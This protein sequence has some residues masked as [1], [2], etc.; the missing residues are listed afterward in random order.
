MSKSWLLRPSL[1]I[2]ALLTKSNSALLNADKNPVLNR[3]LRWAIYNHFCAGTNS[4]EVSKAVEDVKRLGYHGIILGYA[5]EVVLD[6]VEALEHTS[7]GDAKYGAMHYE[8]IDEWKRGNLETLEMLGSGDFIALK[9]T[10]AGP[11]A[12]DAM[13][14]GQPMP[15]YLDSALDEICY[16]TNKKG[17][18]V[19]LDA[20]QQALQ[21]TLDEWAIG[22]MRKHNQGGRA[23][24]YNT[25]QGYLKGSKANAERHI[26]LAAQEG[27]T[28]AIKLV[29]GAYI[30]NEIRSLIH[31]TKEDTDRSYDA[32][33]DMFISRKMPEG[34]QNLRFPDAALFLATHNAKS[35]EKGLRTHKERVLAGLPTTPLE[36]GQILGMAD[37]LSCKLLQD[38]DKSAADSNMGDKSPRILKCIPWGSVGECMGYLYRRAVENRGAVERTQHMAEAMR[39]EVR[40]RVLG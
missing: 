10:G 9:L 21:P 28:V 1:A 38:H 19:W 33:A 31:D 27:W 4:R 29:R 40:R 24:L 17:C 34:V 20:E 5:K 32:I 16:E 13:Q 14:A 26:T 35:A 30:E 18:R 2:M 7:S 6:P 12:L 39:R 25:I 23:L 15:K 11:I 37:E 22:L 3:V 8:V 36:C